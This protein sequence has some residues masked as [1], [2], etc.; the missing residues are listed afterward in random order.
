MKVATLILLLTFPG[1]SFGKDRLK[2]KI[3]STCDATDKDIHEEYVVEYLP[4][5]EEFEATVYSGPSKKK[6][7][8]KMIMAVGRIWKYEINANEL[9]T[10]LDHENV[11]IFDPELIPVFNEM[12]QC[13]HSNWK[14]DEVVPCTGKD[15]VDTEVI[16]GHRTI[17][18]FKL[19]GNDLKIKRM[20]G[21][22]LTLKRRTP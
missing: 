6:C 7:F 18:T 8:G 11:I 13:N 5:N 3:F 16:E 22:R 17:H 2:G 1:L 9:I 14:V 15:V 21:S 4:D 12:K 20:D 19:Q 10:T